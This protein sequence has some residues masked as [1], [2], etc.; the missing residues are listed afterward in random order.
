MNDEIKMPP[1]LDELPPGINEAWAI[2]D[3][4]E[5]V[6]GSNERVFVLSS[7]AGHYYAAYTWSPTRGWIHG[8]GERQACARIADL[9]GNHDGW[10][11]VAAVAEATIARWKARAE[12]AE[13]EFALLR[14]L[15]ESLKRER[16]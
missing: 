2:A 1:P 16:A 7:E 5:D 3:G 4:W 13:R 10:Q 12:T 11:Q 14:D 6:T 9:R 15:V 8:F